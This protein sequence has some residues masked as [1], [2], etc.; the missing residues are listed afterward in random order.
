MKRETLLEIILGTIGG[1]VFAI[2]MCMC[3]L[4]EWN[5][6]TTGV[7]VAIIGFII[8]LCIIPVYKNS[9]PKKAKENKPINWGIVLTWTVGVVGALIMGF[10]MSKIMVGNAETSDMV[11]GLITGVVGL[12]ICVLNYPIYAYIKSNKE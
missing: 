2:G 12:V 3:L 4:P 10:G 1:L 11:V 5:M 8:L 6:F 7:V 9:H